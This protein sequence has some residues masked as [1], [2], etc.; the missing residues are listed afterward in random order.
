[1]SASTSQELAVTVL[2]N[3]HNGSA[4]TP[5]DRYLP[6][7]YHHSAAPTVA[8]IVL[9]VAAFVLLIYLAPAIGRSRGCGYRV[10]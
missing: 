6:A 8:A 10:T 4:G 9:I 5:L 2:S 7:A 3:G 1:M